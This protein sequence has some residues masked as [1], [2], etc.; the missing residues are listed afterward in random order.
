MI[1]ILG[2]TFKMGRNDGDIRERPEFTVTVRDFWIAKTEVTNAEYEQFVRETGYPAP[3]YWIGNH[4]PKGQEMM[5]VVYVDMKDIE[6]FIKW[7]SNRDGIKY[8]LPTEEE[9][10]YAA[11]NG[12]NNNLYP[13]GDKWENDRAAVEVFRVMPVGSFPK[14]ANK[15]GVLDLIGNV[16]EWT[17]SKIKPYPGAK[18]VFNKPNN[19]VIRGGCFNSKASGDRAITSTTRGDVE[20]TRKDGLLGFRLASDAD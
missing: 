1:K 6:E 15:W 9:W 14:G 2:G 3:S 4:P 7:R 10:E 20:P 16:W 11:R 5:P 8:R 13:W 12:S 17:S 19:F 18:I